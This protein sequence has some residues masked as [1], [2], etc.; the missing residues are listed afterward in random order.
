MLKIHEDAQKLID[1]WTKGLS[2]VTTIQPFPDTIVTVAKDDKE[3]Y[4]ITAYFTI[5][6]TWHVSADAQGVS[7]DKA[8]EEVG[9]RL[10]F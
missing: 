9:R 6:N 2:V 3:Q 10:T 7:A 8:F 5:G 1:Q 4:H